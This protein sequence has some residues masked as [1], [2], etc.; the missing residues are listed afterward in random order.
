MHRVAEAIAERLRGVPSRDVPAR[1]CGLAVELLPVVGASVSLCGWGLPLRVGASDAAAAGLAE[2]QATLGD[3]PCV[4]AVHH[5][6]P[7]LARDLTAGRDARRWPVFAQ[8]ATAAGVRAAY[9]IPLGSGTV[10]LGTLDLYGAEPGELFDADLRTARLL[11]AMVTL[12]LVAL[13]RAPEGTGPRTAWLNG[14]AAD[15]DEI[16]QAVGMIMAQLRVPPDE[17]LDLLR[18]HAFACGRTALEVAHDMVRRRTCLDR[19]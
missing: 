13:P 10:C 17:A 19:V 18:A 11:A 9:S 15:H 3:G 7:V 5:I 1:L 12:A 6:A 16:P 8:Q 2:T 14:L 4:S